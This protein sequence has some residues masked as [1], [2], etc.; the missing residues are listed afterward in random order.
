MRKLV[1]FTAV[2][3]SLAVYGCSHS[4]GSSGPNAIDVALVPVFASA[5]VTPVQADDA[6][7]CRRLSADLLGHYATADE[8]KH[9]CAGKSVDEIARSFQSRPEYV[10][11]SERVWRDRMGTSDILVDWRELQD[12]YGLV[13]K[14][15]QGKMKYSQFA[16]DAMAHPGFVMKTFDPEDKVNAVFQAFLGRPA[17]QAERADLGALYRP[18]IP[19]QKPDPD[20]PYLMKTVS[21]VFPV[22]CDPLTSCSSTMYGGGA[23]DLSSISDP[24]YQGVDWDTLTEAQKD[25]L[26]EPGRI[27]TAQHFFWEA[28]ADEILERLLGWSDGGRFPRLPG[29]VLPDVREVLA[30]YLQK[31]DS[32]PAGERLVLDSWLY[33]MKAAVPDDGLG[34]DP[35][36]P[37]PQIYATGPVKPGTAEVWLDSIKPLTIDLGACDARYADG[38]PY[39]LIAQ[40]GQQGVIPASQVPVDQKKLWTLEKSKLPWSDQQ[41]APDFTYTG[42]ARL[43]GGC[44]GYQSQRQPQTGLSYAFTQESLAEVLCDN[45]VAQHLAPPSGTDLKSILSHQMELV[46]GR[47]PTAQDLADYQTAVA[48]C[49]GADCTTS[50]IENSVCVGLLGGAEMVFY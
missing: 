6:E 38:F 29:V 24:Q 1:A 46:Y 9:D 28:E 20:F 25:A 21:L 50:G 19:S 16:I 13:D 33:R 3:G 49:S 41:N 10:D 32:V 2:A 47:D 11:V 4:K 35:A 48:G 23:L 42:V 7:L 17:T 30:D 8:V 31:T 39:F 43:I 44:P 5:S 18:W 36:A 27:L 34:N 45:G 12:L 40:A 15:S 14:M 22:F 26:R 37:V